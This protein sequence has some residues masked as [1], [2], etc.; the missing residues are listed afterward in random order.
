MWKLKLASK[1]AGGPSLGGLGTS[2]STSNY[3]KYA[4]WCGLSTAGLLLI[5]GILDIALNTS[6]LGKAFPGFYSIVIALPIFL[7]EFPFAPI[8]PLIIAHDF[9]TD[10]RFHAG[11]F[12][13]TSVVAFFSLYTLIGA[14]ASIG[15]GC[16]YGFCYFK[17]EKGLTI[18]ELKKAKS[19]TETN[20]EEGKEKKFS[21]SSLGL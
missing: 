1:L 14:L 18:E 8:K 10:F 6:S 3:K 11:F 9:F 12:G 13:V 21:L 16:F 15:T 4:R 5:F 17:G 20:Q 7:L 19:S 2:T